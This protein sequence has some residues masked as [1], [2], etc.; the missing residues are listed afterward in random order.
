MCCQKI[1]YDAKMYYL[2]NKD[3]FDIICGPNIHL[4]CFYCNYGFHFEFLLLKDFY[5]NDHFQYMDV[6]CFKIP[7]NLFQGGSFEELPHLDNNHI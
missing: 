1:N 4:P 6:Y 7:N 2:R 3:N 5:T